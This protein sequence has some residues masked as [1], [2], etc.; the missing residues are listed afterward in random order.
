MKEVL[1]TMLMMNQQ[2]CIPLKKTN[3][4]SNSNNMID[5]LHSSKTNI[6]TNKYKIKII[7]TNRIN[8]EFFN[9]K[10]WAIYH[11]FV[12]ESNISCNLLEMVYFSV[13]EKENSVPQVMVVLQVLMFHQS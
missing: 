13:V 7:T 6:W 5:N 3:S 10:S 9:K 12:L 2:K 8:K 11:K 1:I 4:N